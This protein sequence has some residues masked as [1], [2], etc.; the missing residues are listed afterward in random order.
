LNVQQPGQILFPLIVEGL[1]HEIVAGGDISDHFNH[2]SDISEHHT[3]SPDQPEQFSSSASFHLPENEL[4][5]IEYRLKC[6]VIW[7]F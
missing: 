5:L 6:N 2:L 3:L 4:W 1:D 7:Q